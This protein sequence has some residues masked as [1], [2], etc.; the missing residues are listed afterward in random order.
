MTSNGCIHQSWCIGQWMYSWTLFKQQKKIC[1]LKAGRGF[2]SQNNKKKLKTNKK[3][4]K[5]K[6]TNQRANQ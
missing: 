6:P 2:V 4:K 5:I 3:K 1:L